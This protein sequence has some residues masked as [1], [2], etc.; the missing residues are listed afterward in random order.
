MNEIIT[1]KFYNLDF[2]LSDGLRRRIWP[3]PPVARQIWLV[4]RTSTEPW[5]LWIFTLHSKSYFVISMN[6]TEI[7]PRNEDKVKKL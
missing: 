6:I 4:L 1:C 2:I 3:F 7:M 5:W